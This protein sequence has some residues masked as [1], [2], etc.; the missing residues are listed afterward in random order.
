M[1]VD[2]FCEPL[3]VP[4]NSGGLILNVRLVRQIKRK[5]L[6]TVPLSIF[7]RMRKF[8][9]GYVRAHD[10]LRHSIKYLRLFQLSFCFHK[11]IWIS[12]VLRG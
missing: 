11:N 12:A 4:S 5:R 1:Q 8:N 9:L 10:M 6:N 7:D 3:H 2:L